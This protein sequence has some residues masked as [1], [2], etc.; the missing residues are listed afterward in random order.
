MNFFALPFFMLEVCLAGKVS[1]M[2]AHVNSV[3]SYRHV[4]VRMEC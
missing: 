2:N 3:L 4:L 1:R